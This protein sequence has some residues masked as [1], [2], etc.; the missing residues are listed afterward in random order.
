M[1]AND[2]CGG[3]SQFGGTK[4]VLHRP[5]QSWQQSLQQLKYQCVIKVILVLDSKHNILPTTRQKINSILAET[6]T[7]SQPCS[8]PKLQR[9]LRNCRFVSQQPVSI[10]AANC[11]GQP[12]KP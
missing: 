10:L 8:E 1:G 4:M 7:L 5:A 2:A 12:Y 6:R 11:L 9:S 3:I